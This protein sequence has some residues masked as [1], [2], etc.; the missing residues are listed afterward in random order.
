MTEAPENPVD[1]AWLLDAAQRLPGDPGVTDYGALVAAAARVDAVVLGRRVYDQPHH[2][3]AALLQQLARVPALER[4][5]GLFAAAAAVA[6]LATCGVTTLPDL[7]EAA[8]LA[9]DAADGRVD[10]RAISWVLR[11]WTTVEG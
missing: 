8:R 4:A 9:A 2:Q 5:N 3:A 10:I 6:Y 1:I 11:Q 7:K